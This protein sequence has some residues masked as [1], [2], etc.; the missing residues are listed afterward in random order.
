VSPKHYNSTLQGAGAIELT[1]VWALENATKG[2]EVERIKALHVRRRP[3]VSRQGRTNLG[4]M[5][6]RTWVRDRLEGLLRET[7]I[8]C[9]P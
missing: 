5:K 7:G 1:P 6:D 3:R 4:V 8:S 2:G 9:D